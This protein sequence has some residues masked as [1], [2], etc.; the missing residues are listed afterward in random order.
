[1][2]KVDAHRLK[3]ARRRMKN[4]AYAKKSRNKRYSLI[5]TNEACKQVVNEVSTSR[6]ALEL[7]EKARLLDRIQQLEARLIAS[8]HAVAP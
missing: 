1:M 6:T 7:D 3:Q 8:G 5:A 4:R 2:Q